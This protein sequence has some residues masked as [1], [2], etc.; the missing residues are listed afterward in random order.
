MYVYIYIYVYSPA[1][2]GRGGGKFPGVASGGG[3]GGS[4]NLVPVQCRCE[5]PGSLRPVQ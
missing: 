1:V 5:K 2:P 3:V 4:S